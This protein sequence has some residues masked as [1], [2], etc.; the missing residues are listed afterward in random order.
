LIFDRQAN[1]QDDVIS[2][3]SYCGSST[4]L[5]FIPA[6]VKKMVSG[7]FSMQIFPK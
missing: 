1:G 5:D 6:T 3:V 7:H 4:L 2:L